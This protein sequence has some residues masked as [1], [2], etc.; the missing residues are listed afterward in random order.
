MQSKN[1]ISCIPV[2]GNPGSIIHYQND[3]LHKIHHTNNLTS[4]HM[5]IR[6]DDDNL[7][8]LNG[9]HW[10][11]TLAIIIKKTLEKTLEKSTKLK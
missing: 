3:A 7:I 10:S 8:N 2:S 6:D 11:C 4:L 1:I 9:L 5:Q